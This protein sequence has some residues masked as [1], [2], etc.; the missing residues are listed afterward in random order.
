MNA[1]PS[2]GR[3]VSAGAVINNFVHFERQRFDERQGSI[4]AASAQQLAEL[5]GYLEIT[6]NDYEAANDRYRDSLARYHVIVEAIKE[7]TGGTA[8]PEEMTA[9][10]LELH[11][12][13]GVDGLRVYLRIDTFYVFAKILLDKLA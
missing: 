1:T 2:P 11:D 8:S 7:R 4:L 10:E 12:E 3:T 6:A 9:E 13:V 5:V